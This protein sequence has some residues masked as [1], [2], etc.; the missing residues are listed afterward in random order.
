ML[1]AAVM[2]AFIPEPHTLLM[3]LAGVVFGRPPKMDACRAGAWPM[4]ACSTQPMN[5]SSMCSGCKFAHGAVPG[6]SS[7][8]KLRRE[9]PPELRPSGAG[10]TVRISD[11]RQSSDARQNKAIDVITI[12]A[13]SLRCCEGFVSTSLPRRRHAAPNP[14]SL[15]HANAQ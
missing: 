12:R 15:A 14:G 6:Y 3:V 8:A 11:S 1:C 9:A 7:L 10:Q 4:P 13:L 2:I 5:T